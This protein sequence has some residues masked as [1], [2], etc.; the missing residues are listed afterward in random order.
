MNILIVKLS[1][2]GDVVQTIP[3]FEVLRKHYAGAHI[4][5]LV[6]EGAA[7]LLEYY[8]GLD[9]IYVCHRKSWLKRMKKPFLW[10]AVCLE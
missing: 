8:P 3:V 4:S 5:W 1:A 6:E 9:E 7:E 10:P 2:L